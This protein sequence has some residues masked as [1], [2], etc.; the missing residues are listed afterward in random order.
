MSK[1]IYVPLEHIDARYTIHLDRDITTHLE[2]HHPEFIKLYPDVTPSRPLPAGMFLDAPFTTKFKSLQ[3]AELANL[4]ET[5]QIQDGD[6]IFFSDLWFPGIES[7]AYM[8]H[9]TGKNVKIRGLLHAGSFTDTDE[10]R[11]FERWAKNFEDVI[12]DLV[13]R[14][15]V[16]SEFIKNDVS[17]KRFIDPAKI[18]V[19]PFP[20]DHMNL[21]L[22]SE[23]K[24]NDPILIFNGRDHIEKQPW[25]WKQIQTKLVKRWNKLNPNIQ[26]PFKFIW[27]QEERLS[28][29]EYYK[30][31]AKSSAVI[32]FA[33]Q[34]NFGYGIA[35]ATYLGCVPIL[36]NRL[37]YPELY[38]SKCL[39]DTFEDAIDMTYHAL[40]N[41]DGF[42]SSINYNACNNRML[43]TCNLDSIKKWFI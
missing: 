28:K 2:Q 33:L 40:T 31:L 17:K 9:F 43:T 3:L 22:Y 4:Y 15:Y 23:L 20:L 12:F 29:S 34:E 7:I 25:L 21:N 36:P 30:L 8:N 19:T 26:C 13:D 6:I 18:E 32:S 35:E 27:T 5:D 41:Y 24:K 37:V 10:V 38:N 42:M 14:V 39:Y 11:Q 16:A 1:I